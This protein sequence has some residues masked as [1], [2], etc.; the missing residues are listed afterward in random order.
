M[1]R[2]METSVTSVVHAARPGK[3]EPGHPDLVTVLPGGLGRILLCPK[4]LIKDEAF[5]VILRI[6]HEARGR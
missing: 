5:H 4:P 3:Q 6:H 2:R 1:G